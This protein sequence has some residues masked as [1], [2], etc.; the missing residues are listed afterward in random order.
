M[1]TLTPA[2]TRVRAARRRCRGGEVPGSVVRQTSSSS[3][4][5]ENVTE[6]SARAD[7]SASTSASRTISG[8]RVMIEKGLWAAKSSSRQARV[9]LYRPSA[10]WYGSVAA[11]IATPSPRQLSRASSRC[12]TSATFVFTRIERP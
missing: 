12:S 5:T 4:G 6:T 11:P 9:S 2:S 10:G 3:V 8:P 1:P 7:A